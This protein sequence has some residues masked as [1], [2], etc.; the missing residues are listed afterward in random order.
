M[1][2]IVGG[3]IVLRMILHGIEMMGRIDTLLANEDGVKL[4]RLCGP[5]LYEYCFEK[6]HKITI[7]LNLQ[8][9]END[10]RETVL[11]EF[12]SGN[13]FFSFEH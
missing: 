8:C 1:R 12:D 4:V 7:Y 2:L 5:Q 3:A 10:F 6:Q 11:G 13:S 9:L